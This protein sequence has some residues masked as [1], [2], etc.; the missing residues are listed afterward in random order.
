MKREARAMPDMS[1][2]TGNYFRGQREAREIRADQ[3]YRNQTMQV[4]V[5][6]LVGSW[7]LA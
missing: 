2:Q 7:P 6:V 3:R 1:P 4:L 5:S